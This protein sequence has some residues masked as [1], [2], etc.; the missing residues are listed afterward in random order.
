MPTPDSAS[1]PPPVLLAQRW[2]AGWAEASVASS[3][4]VTL[5]GEQGLGSGRD[6]GLRVLG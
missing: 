5:L 3:G 2:R 4:N 1:P 6:A